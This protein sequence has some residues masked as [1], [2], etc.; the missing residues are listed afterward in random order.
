MAG[1][2]TAVV[3][4][5]QYL[6]GLAALLV[7]VFHLGSKF[8]ELTGG[9]AH[10]DT[11]KSGVDIFFIISGFVIV[12]STRC[13]TSLTPWNFMVR[14]LLRI[15]PLYWA[16]TLGFIAVLLVLPQVVKTSRLDWMHALSGL[17][18]LPARNPVGG[19]VLPLITVGWTLN[20]EMSFYVFFAIA[21][22]VAKG[23]PLGILLWTALPMALLA[24][25][26]TLFHPQG[27]AGFYA[28]A[29]LLEFAAGMLIARLFMAHPHF[30]VRG[31]SVVLA[32][33]ALLG[34]VL[35]L[36]PDEGPLAWRC[37][38]YGLPASMLVAGSVWG[39][40]TGYPLLGLLGEISYSM[41]LSH[42]FTVSA[43][44][45]LWQRFGPGFGGIKTALFYCGGVIASLAVSFLVWRFV[46][47]P[48]NETA[49]RLVTGQKRGRSES[50]SG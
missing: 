17:L 22:V 9:D 29:I 31:G 40:W 25:T 14:R 15:A 26:A 50:A 4:G 42:F 45:Q 27:V 10:L 13:G 38:R 37:L 49:K 3:D 33:L 43:Y 21:M 16:T 32:L 12:Y 5:V 28:N 39:R 2:R 47:K 30:P 6:R 24:T 36:V 41:Y 11:F 48:L 44:A 1:S 20:L 7:V 19:A 18:F 46:E 34:L 35:L 8:G 23:K